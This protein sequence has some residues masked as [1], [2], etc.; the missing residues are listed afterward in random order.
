MGLRARTGLTFSSCSSA[1]S[2]EQPLSL[3]L[4]LSLSL[5]PP[6][7]YM[8][9]RNLF[10]HPSGR[11]S[12][13]QVMHETTTLTYSF[14]ARILDLPPLVSGER[15]TCT[16]VLRAQNIG[17]SKINAP[18]VKYRDIIVKQRNNPR[19]CSCSI[20]QTIRQT[21]KKQEASK[22]VSHESQY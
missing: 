21:K 4:S 1:A 12:Q 5:I 2:I 7:S 9:I 11:Q 3:S 10:R 14:F 18:K 13:S 19:C 15:W 22:Q 20:P 8:S 17:T 16:F 6:P